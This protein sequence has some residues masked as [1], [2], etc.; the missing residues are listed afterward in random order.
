MGVLKRVGGL[1]VQACQHG[2][3]AHSTDGHRRVLDAQGHCLCELRIVDQ[4]QQK[5]TD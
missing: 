4:L 1:V 5:I 2:D 3:I